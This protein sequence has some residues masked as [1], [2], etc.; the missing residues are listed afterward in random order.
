LSLV[1]LGDLSGNTVLQVL[2][3]VLV[4]SGKLPM[5]FPKEVGQLP[6]YYN[7]KKYRKAYYE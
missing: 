7:Y 6:M 5:T 3:G 1:A 2:Y 4:P